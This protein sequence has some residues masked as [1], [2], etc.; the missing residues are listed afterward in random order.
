MRYTDAADEFDML[1]RHLIQ[2]G[3]GF[4]INA[5]SLAKMGFCMPDL[6]IVSRYRELGGEIVTIGSDAHWA[7]DV[8]SG[9]TGAC[10]M[11][12]AS[13]MRYFCTYEDHKPTFHPL[14]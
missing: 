9:F 3:K 14:P 7:K 8:G 4:E 6:D 10:E 11:L 13:G 5:S 2:N 1:F 12:K